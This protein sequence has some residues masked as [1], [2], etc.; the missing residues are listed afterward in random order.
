M[1]KMQ[2]LIKEQKSIREQPIVYSC[3]A[4]VQTWWNWFRL[5]RARFIENRIYGG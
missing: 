3:K 2:G 4:P 5:L 1:W